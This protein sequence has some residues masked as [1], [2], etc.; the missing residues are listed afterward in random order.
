MS[1]QSLQAADPENL[2]FNLFRSKSVKASNPTWMCDGR[3]LCSGPLVTPIVLSEN[4][5]DNIQEKT[6]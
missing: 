1:S 2:A 6:G 5:L 4:G 3:S